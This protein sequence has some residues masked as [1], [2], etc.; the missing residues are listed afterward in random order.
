MYSRIN[1]GCSGSDRLEEVLLVVVHREHEHANL[2][3]AVR[4]LTR[5]AVRFPRHRDVDDGQVDVLGERVFNCLLAIRCF[6]HDLQIRLS[7]IRSQRRTI[8]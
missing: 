7:T 4:D 5:L 8:G 2:W 3:L 1:A 6:G